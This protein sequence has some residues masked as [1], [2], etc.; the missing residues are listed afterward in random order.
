MG[1]DIA[2]GKVSHSTNGCCIQQLYWWGGDDLEALNTVLL[3][4]RTRAD[5]VYTEIKNAIINLELSPGSI[6][7]EEVLAQRL[8][9]SRTPIREALRRLAQDGFVR[10]LS[11]KG[12]LVSEITPG[13]VLEIFEVRMSLEPLAARL[14]ARRMPVEEIERLQAL[15]PAPHPG[16]KGFLVGF[17]ELHRS[18]SRYSGNKRLHFILG[19]LMDE[20]TRIL[21]TGGF[22]EA[23]RAHTFHTEIIDAIANRDPLRAELVMQE[24]LLDFRRT[25]LA[26][27]AN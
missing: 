27:L 15:H 1:I 16:T 4:G 23:T 24:H 25:F 13:D 7:Q 10:I 19:P 6:V 21:A 26:S 5:H 12:T 8:G 3:R 18:I 17:R 20:T 11:K 22:E 2:P 14:A 9:V